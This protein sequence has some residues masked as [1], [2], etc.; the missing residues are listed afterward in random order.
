MK[1]I[2]HVCLTFLLG[3]GLLQAQSTIRGTVTS[4]ED[5]SPLPGVN[6]LVKGTTNGTVT[7]S[8]GKYSISISGENRVF[9]VSFIGFLSKEVNADKRTVVD[10]KLEQDVKMMEEAV[11]IGYGTVNKTT[12]TGSSAQVG[13]GDIEK[14]PNSNALNSLVGAAPGV[15]T[16]MSGGAPGSA[17]T[18]RVRGFGSISASNSA[19]Y[20]VD[21]VPYSGS[22]SNLN[23]DDIES[24]SVLKDAST[25]AIYGSRG[26]NGVVLITTKKGKVGRSNFSLSASGGSISRGLPEYETVSAQQYYPLMWEAYRNN[27]LYGATLIPRETANSIASGLTTS[28]A[29][30]TYSGIASL[31][32]YNP[33]NVAAN[34]IV[35]VNGALNPNAQL[36]YGDD[37]NWSK[38]LQRGGKSRQN[39]VLS[40]D[41]GSAKSDYFVSLG[42]TSEKGYLIKSDFKRFT[43]RV[44][45]N[46][47][48]TKWLKTGININASYAMSNVDGL[49]DASTSIVN[50]FN[51]S[52]FIGPIYPVYKHD[53]TTGAYVLDE[54]GNKVYDQGDSRPYTP[55]RHAIWE[56]ELN[57]KYQVRGTV[58]ARTF[59]TVNILPFL[60]ATSNL[61]FDL[62]DTHYRRFDNAIIGDGAPAGR[63][64][65]DL[66]RTTSYTWNQLLEFDKAFGKH[67]L[68]V[69]A[70]HEN[71]SYKYNELTGGRTGVIVDGITELPNFATVLSLSSYED[72]HGIESFFSRAS[73]D[74][75]KKYI[76]S[77][78]LRRDGNS[79]FY[80]DV[81][82]ANFWSVGAGYNL[83]RE[84]FFRVSWIDLLKLRT[85]YGV[86]GNDGGLG[87][88]PYQALYNLGRNN[89]GEPGFIQASIA[90]NELTWESAKNFDAGIDFTILNGRLSGSVEYFKRMTDGLI[91]SVPLS[92]SN[93]GTTTGGFEVDKNIGNL[94]NKGFEIQI[95]GEI[96]KTE[97]FSYSTTLNWTTVKNRITK[98]PETQKLII[99]GTKAYS[100]GHSIYDFYLR[101]FYGVDAETGL[102]LY[103]TN[104]SNANTK[105]IG[106]DTLTTIHSEANLRYVGQ[107]AIPKFYGS[108]THN[109]SYKDLS[110]TFLLTYQVGGRVYDGAYA[111]LMHGG[112]YGT[113]MHIDALNRWQN[114][115]DVT[116]V[117]RLDAGAVVNQAGA[118]SRYLTNAS[119]LMLNNVTLSYK[120]PAVV[121]SRIAAKDASIFVSGENLGLLS[122]RKGMNVTGSFNGIVSNS[123]NFNKVLSVGAKLKF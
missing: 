35:D 14:R 13:A 64:Y 80:K 18:I 41:G 16:T 63:A 61:S 9:I 72:N 46:T 4:A 28:Y 120:I 118:S 11:V 83:D 40:Y 6:L 98:M 87:Y 20:V 82:W 8:D 48:A 74:F 17:P 3:V 108:M 78:S 10:I 102:S 22:T 122:H 31:L 69:L 99:D 111:G 70:G 53:A 81:R 79:R 101:D 71:Y 19:L 21:G 113:A 62:Q 57:Q 76:L 86:V 115:G 68:N 47:Q 67:Q 1:R 89:A 121:M 116:E 49:E 23:P 54:N 73:Y 5:G 84:D 7:D 107:S 106:N 12:F 45:V 55:G 104:I 109:L 37:L 50:P 2:L 85:S 25:T 51:I 56:N 30:K 39:Y 114:P 91:F 60:K 38:A 43:G 32:G 42:Y 88:Y 24:I 66:Y 105:I 58:G 52:R 26:A 75:D 33:F 77:A 119:Y 95:T 59:A 123:Y 90:N 44:N 96:V 65:H 15:Q 93:G 117:S 103:K 34:Q 97:N 92:L 27:L 36:L 112:T 110:L 94:Y 29:G 100:V